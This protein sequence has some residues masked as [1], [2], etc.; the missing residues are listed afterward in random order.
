MD[1]VFPKLSPSKKKNNNKINKNIYFNFSLH[2]PIISML[3]FNSSKKC[4]F[5]YIIILILICFDYLSPYIYRP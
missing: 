2:K 4:N 5:Q 1:E 3:F